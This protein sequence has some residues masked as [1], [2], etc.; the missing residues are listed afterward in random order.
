MRNRLRGAGLVRLAP[1]VLA[2]AL[3][4]I[5]GGCQDNSTTSNRSQCKTIADLVTHPECV[6]SDPTAP[7]CPFTLE[8]VPVAG[9]PG[10]YVVA[11]NPPGDYALYVNATGQSVEFGQLVNARAGDSIVGCRACGC[12]APVLLR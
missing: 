1:L 8:A 7:G 12:S 6:G 5:G 4:G 9:Y 11:P 3:L 2:L 10:L